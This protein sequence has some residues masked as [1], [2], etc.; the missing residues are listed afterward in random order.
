MLY[1][2]SRS[3]QQNDYINYDGQSPGRYISSFVEI[4]TMVQKMILE[5]VLSYMGWEPS[6]S[7]DLN[8][9]YIISFPHPNDVPRKIRIWLIKSFQRTFSFSFNM[10]MTVDQGQ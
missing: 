1:N 8:H 2:K 10:L 9:L 4:S 6:R 5:G 3:T 7:R